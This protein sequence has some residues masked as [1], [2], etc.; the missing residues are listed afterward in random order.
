MTF[1]YIAY[2]CLCLSISVKLSLLCIPLL[3]NY[4]ALLFQLYLFFGGTCRLFPIIVLLPTNILYKL[5][6]YIIT[7]L[8]THFSLSQTL[9]AAEK[10]KKNTH[11]HTHRDSQTHRSTYLNLIHNPPPPPPKKKKK[12]NNPI[13]QIHKFWL[14]IYSIVVQ[15]SVLWK[16]IFRY[17]RNTC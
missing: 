3:W 14:E 9:V 11:T 1:F 8:R 12:H 15:F 6:L 7:L 16:Y 5:F 4:N 2:F 10:K 17:Y 13:W